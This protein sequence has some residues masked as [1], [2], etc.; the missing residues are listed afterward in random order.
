[1][2][3]RRVLLFCRIRLDNVEPPITVEVADSDVPGRVKRTELDTID[4]KPARSIIQVDNTRFQKVALNNVEEAIAVEIAYGNA[5]CWLLVTE[6]YTAGREI[7]R[8][9]IEIEITI[10][11]PK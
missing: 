7:A 6:R 8:P 10:P 1:M 5:R 4:G 3:P 2:F 11:S 9:I